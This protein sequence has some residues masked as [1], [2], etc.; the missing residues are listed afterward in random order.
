MKKVVKLR[1]NGGVHEVLI[2]AEQTLLEVLRKNLGLTGVKAG[3]EMGSCG[4][5]TVLVDGEPYLSCIMLALDA[6]GKEVTTIEGLSR[7]KELHPIQES[8]IQKGA[9]QCGY[10]TPGMILT[11]KSILDEEP[12][13][14][15]EV[16]KFK[17]AGNLC[18]CTGYKKIVDAIMSVIQEEN[19]EKNPGRK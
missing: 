1:V 2:S 14:T 13:P 5:C 7:G 10:C 19:Q 15:E 4:A 17:M 8:F 3:C 9:L 16:I 18:R 6:A 12:S 11:A